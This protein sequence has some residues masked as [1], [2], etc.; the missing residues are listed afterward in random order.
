M[1]LSRVSLRSSAAFKLSMSTGP[2]RHRSPSRASVASEV[3]ISTS[4]AGFTSIDERYHFGAKPLAAR[5]R[6]RTIHAWHGEQA[7]FQVLIPL[8]DTHNKP[9]TLKVEVSD[10]FEPDTSDPAL[11]ALECV[12]LFVVKPVRADMQVVYDRLEPLPLAP[13]RSQ[14]GSCMDALSA[15]V[16]LPADGLVPGNSDPWLLPVPWVPGRSGRRGRLRDSATSDRF[17]LLWGYIHTPTHARSPSTYSFQRAASEASAAAAAPA[18]A[19]LPT[20]TCTLRL[21]FESSE[22]IVSPPPGSL[23]SS[24]GA[25]TPPSGSVMSLPFPGASPPPPPGSGMSLPF[26]GA[27]PAPP[28]RGSAI[29]TAASPAL[30]ASALALSSPPTQTS[31]SAV[32]A[33]PTAAVPPTA[34][35]PSGSSVASA[36]GSQAS[37]HSVAASLQQPGQAPATQVVGPVHIPLSAEVVDSISTYPKVVDTTEL[38]LHL[39]T[40]LPI[41]GP[42]QPT[43]A[44]GVLPP[45]LQH[46]SQLHLWQNPFSIAEYHR[47]PLWSPA[48][49]ALLRQNYALLAETGCSSVTA[50]VLHDPWGSQTHTPYASMVKWVLTTDEG[51]SSALTFDFSV[52]DAWVTLCLDLGMGPLINCYSILPWAPD[53]GG[54]EAKAAMPSQY[55]LYNATAQRLQRMWAHPLQP[56]YEAMWTAFLTAFQA[57]LHQM[58]WLGITAVGVDERPPEEMRRAIALVRRVAPGLRIALAGNYHQELED[59]VDDWCVWL[60][61]PL[62]PPGVVPKRNATL[63]PSAQHAHV[64]V[65]DE[66]SC[67]PSRGGHSPLDNHSSPSGSGSATA[68]SAFA[69][70]VDGPGSSAGSSASGQRERN[71]SIAVEPEQGAGVYTP[72]LSPGGSVDDSGP[73]GEAARNTQRFGCPSMHVPVAI[74]EPKRGIPPRMEAAAAALCGRRTTTYYTC[75]GPVSPNTFTGSPPVEAAWLGLYGEA[76]GYD[77]YLRWAY[78]CWGAEPTVDTRYRPQFWRAGDC[79]LAYPNAQ[80][81]V[82]LLL[83]RQGLVMAEKQ[84]ISAHAMLQTLADMGAAPSAAQPFSSAGLSA[85]LLGSNTSQP[86]PTLGLMT[87]QSSSLDVSLVPE[88]HAAPCAAISGANIPMAPPAAAIRT[89]RLLAPRGPAPP[90]A[91]WRA[92][93]ESHVEPQLGER[94]TALARLLNAAACAGEQRPGGFT[95]YDCLRDASFTALHGVLASDEATPQLWLAAALAVLRGRQVEDFG[96]WPLPSWPSDTL[97]E[98]EA[99]IFAKLLESKRV[100]DWSEHEVAQVH[101]QA[102][103]HAGLAPFLKWVAP[104]HLKP[105]ELFGPVLHLPPIATLHDAEK[106]VSVQVAEEEEPGMQSP[107]LPRVAHPVVSKAVHAARTWQLVVDLV[108]ATLLEQAKARQ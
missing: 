21:T 71:S 6:S 52:F 86:P 38:T 53:G 54:S 16:P 28:P 80:P 108:L 45:P 77:G 65:Q 106:A 62:P 58:G 81:S 14:D 47:V 42:G 67:S 91:V 3:D 37:A 88:G 7:H 55:A 29:P 68:L 18:A 10:F 22:P 89:Q 99:G 56:T 74:P 92:V 78:D 34:V 49:W 5:H 84:R 83:L 95:V 40:P 2:A 33:T 76:N 19:L 93:V 69:G 25:S 94:G 64:I 39:T 104:H 20:Y 13:R 23:Q 90:Q 72:F 4:G 66:A 43:P 63:P 82:R 100:P 30:A 61:N 44:Y 11:S 8:P 79:Y 50:T 59:T 96:A 85:A 60:R 24:V 36:D 12:K 107:F 15:E 102:R 46:E 9:L 35:G 27:S 105:S 31:A 103:K 87:H 70:I 41:P 51:G 1:P 98:E 17:V 26:P 101:A 32:A 57:H 75:C 48:H 73:H 97:A